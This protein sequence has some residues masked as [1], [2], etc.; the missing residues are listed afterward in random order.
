MRL[1]VCALSIMSCHVKHNKSIDNEKMKKKNVIEYRSIHCIP[2][3]SQL[4]SIQINNKKVNE[5]SCCPGPRVSR[6]QPANDNG[7]VGNANGSLQMWKLLNK[8][9]E[10]TVKLNL[11]R[12]GC[13]VCARTMFRKWKSWRWSIYRH[14]N[15]LKSTQFKLF[16]IGKIED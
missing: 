6:L 11:N 5:Y 13:W 8:E 3:N 9:E 16:A 4:K 14:D 1:C 12:I 15:W 7:C 10:K 2:L